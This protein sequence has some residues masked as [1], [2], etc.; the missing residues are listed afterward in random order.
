MVG[1]HEVL[2]CSGSFDSIGLD[3]SLG[4]GRAGHGNPAPTPGMSLRI[5]HI[6]LSPP[7]HCGF[8]APIATSGTV[9]GPKTR[10]EQSKKKL[11]CPCQVPCLDSCAVT[12][13]AVTALIAPPQSRSDCVLRG[14]TMSG[15]PQSSCFP[16]VNPFFRSGTPTAGPA[17]DS[18]RG[19]RSL[20]APESTGCSTRLTP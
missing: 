1:G 13:I 14:A 15:Q 10:R 2:L 6:E 18:G 8:H 9:C 4:G 19:S 20:S 17:G 11:W 3:D 7:F 16:P 12:P 5:A